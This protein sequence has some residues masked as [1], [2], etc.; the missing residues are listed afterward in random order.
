MNMK[1]Q[2][3]DDPTVTDCPFCLNSGKYTQED[4]DA[5]EAAQEWCKWLDIFEES[6]RDQVCVMPD[7]TLSFGSALTL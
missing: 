4:L 6:D 5:I 2:M 3:C 7:D 1:C